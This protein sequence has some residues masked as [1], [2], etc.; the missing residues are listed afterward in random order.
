MGKQQLISENYRELNRQLHADRD[1]YGTS[2]IHFAD[3]IGGLAAAIGTD[4]ILDYGAGKQTLANALPQYAIK[5][6]DPAIESISTYPQPADLVVCTDVLEHIE[7][8]CLDAVLDEIQ[9]LTKRVAFVT[10]ATTPAKKDLPDG[11]NAH[12]TI[13]SYRWWL[14][15]LWTRFKIDQFQTLADLHFMIVMRPLEDK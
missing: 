4:D 11:R 2:G 12:L 9:R 10:V 7:P 14:P 8:E 13:E 1:D 6:Y 15:K 3:Y 5:S